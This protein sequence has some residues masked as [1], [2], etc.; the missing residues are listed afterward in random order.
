MIIMEGRL[1][2][3]VQEVKQRSPGIRGLKKATDH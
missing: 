3:W 1:V 2:R